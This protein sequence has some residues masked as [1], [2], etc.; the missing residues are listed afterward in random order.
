MLGVIE[1]TLDAWVIRVGK[2]GE[3]ID[4]GLDH[5]ARRTAVDGLVKLLAAGRQKAI[6]ERRRLIRQP[7]SR[8]SES[9]RQFS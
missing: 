2:D 5:C 9:R 4:P 1:E 8:R 3:P 6:A 7:G